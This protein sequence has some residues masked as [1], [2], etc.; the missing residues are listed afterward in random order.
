MNR[1]SRIAA[2]IASLLAASAQAQTTLFTINVTAK[3]YEADAAETPVATSVVGRAQLQRQQSPNVGDA[4]RHEPGMAVASDSAQGQNPVIRGLGKERMVLLVDGMRFNS[5]QPVGAIASF[6]S[7]G[8]A[9]RVEVVKGPA[10]VLYGTGALGGA[11]NVQMPQAKFEPGLGLRAQAGFDSASRGLRGAAVGNFSEGDHALMLGLSASKDRDYKAPGGKVAHTGYDSRAFIGQY[12][13]R[14]DGQQQLRVSAQHER[15]DDVW[16]PG[17]VRRHPLANVVGNTLTH[18]PRQE[19]TLYEVGYSRRGA[20]AGE[21]NVDARV[22]RQEMHR[23]IYV[24]SSLLGRDIVSND[25]TFA[26]TGVDARADWLVH[27]EHLLSAGVNV[28]RMT[29]SPDSRSARP[30]QFTQW[31]PNLPFTDGKVQAAGIYVQDDMHF[32]PFNVLTRAGVDIVTTLRIDGCDDPRLARYQGWADLVLV[33][34][35]CSGSGTLRRHP[36]LKWRLQPDDVDHYQQLQRTIVLAALRLL[37]PGGRLVYAT[38]SLLA[39]EN[40]QQMQWLAER[41]GSGWQATAQRAWLPG[42][43]GGDAF[44]MAAWEKPG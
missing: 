36:D 8:L 43:Q 37:R 14:L 24:Q 38:C 6:I 31:V 35:P 42:E 44:F 17:S 16:Y 22:Y 40:A 19:R 32:G 30:P 20:V 3:G 21:V 18:S 10:S 9:E 26:T 5:A 28:W 29:A 23:T 27:P 25:V 7:M 1:P 15:E 2:A 4:L 33:D 34:A 13:Y 12:R 11:I 39:D 41:L